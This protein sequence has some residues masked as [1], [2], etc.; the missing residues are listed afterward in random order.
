MS[1]NIQSIF[2][3][4]FR[5]HC[6]GP[7]VDLGKLKASLKLVWDK[8]AKHILEVEAGVSFEACEAH[9]ATKLTELPN[10]YEHG[11]PTED[12]RGC[13][14]LRTCSGSFP[15]QWSSLHVTVGLSR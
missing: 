15:R 14:T 8:R 1:A 2:E 4:G 7:R 11:M 6:R 9:E 5:D 3:V 10:R 12:L 13:R